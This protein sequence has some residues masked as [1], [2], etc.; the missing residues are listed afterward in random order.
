MTKSGKPRHYGL[1]V[2]LPGAAFAWKFKD[3]GI[4]ISDESI[5][6]AIND[7]PYET[8]PSNIAEVHLQ[9]NA[10]GQNIIATCRIR[11]RDGPELLVLSADE[12]GLYADDQ[13]RTYAAFVRDLNRRLADSSQKDIAFTAG[14]SA[15]RQTFGFAL[16][17]LCVAFFLVIPTVLLLI[18]REVSLIPGLYFGLLLVWP[19]YRLVMTN[20]PQ[21][22]DPRAV[23]SEFVDI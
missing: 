21:T 22:Y 3:C 14:Y 23:P 2:R 6:W 17:G 1:Y 13:A 15:E 12:N 7:E 18:S 5:A 19:L 10:V 8:T 11:F 16:I 9:T 4:T 20:A